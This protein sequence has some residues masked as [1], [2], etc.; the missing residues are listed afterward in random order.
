MRLAIYVLLALT[1]LLA[2]TLAHATSSA[3]AGTVQASYYGSELAGSPTA[4]SGTPYNP[5]SLTAAHKSLPCGTRLLVRY[6][7]RGVV[8]T[9]D[10]RGPYAAGRDL[11]LSEGAAQAIGLVESGAGPVEVEQVE[12]AES[13]AQELPKTGGPG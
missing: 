7:G 3:D 2:H 5:S 9:V 11:D 4:C 10:D 12:S 6:G 1:L 13:G 8:V